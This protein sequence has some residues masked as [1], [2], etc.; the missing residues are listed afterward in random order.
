MA[1][2]AVQVDAAAQGLNV[3]FYHVHA[4]APAG[5]VADRIG[6]GEPGFENQVVDFFVGQGCALGDQAAFDGFVQDFFLVQ[7]A[8]VVADFDHDAACVVIGVELER[9]FG[10]FASG[11]AHVGGFDAVIHGVAHQMGQRVAD[12][13]DDG[14]V[15]FGI[16]AADDQIDVLAQ[17]F[18]DIAH[19]AG[20]TV[21]GGADLHHAQGQRGIAD[22]FNQPGQGGGGFDQVGHP[23]AP[24]DQVGARPGN[25]Q[26]AD[27]VDQFIEF[28]GIDADQVGFV[29][30]VV[31]DLLLFFQRG[32]DHRRADDLLFDQHFAD[33]PLRN[34]D[35]FRLE[36]QNVVQLFRG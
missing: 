12:F 4:D 20:E 19:H 18:A 27:Q 14:F 11:D 10:R 30:F 31:F 9:A 28:F 13:F 5:Q 36:T 29:L 22:F 25:N 8:A 1:F 32:F 7:A 16:P 35:L 24:G 6:G 17:F 23:G 33:R 15:E 3:A 26:F 2:D 21:K 34:V